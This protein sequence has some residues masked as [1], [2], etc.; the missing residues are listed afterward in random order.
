[1][2]TRIRHFR[3]GHPKFKKYV[4]DLSHKQIRPTWRSQCNGVT[5]VTLEEAEGEV[6]AEGYSFCHPLD[7]FN[8]RTGVMIARGRA[9]KNLEDSDRHLGYPRRRSLEDDL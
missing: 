8:K 5:L 3:S 2:K 6:I 4:R 9:L 1:M 7:N